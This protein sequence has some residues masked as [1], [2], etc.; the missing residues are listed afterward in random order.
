MT[1]VGDLSILDIDS[2]TLQSLTVTLTNRPDSA[3]E[4]LQANT[5]GLTGSYD[6]ATGIFAVSGTAPVATYEQILESFTY[7]NLSLTPD[8]TTRVVEVTVNDGTDSSV[9][10]T[11][12]IDIVPDQVTVSYTH[13]TLPTNREV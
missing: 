12:F 2:T 7:E 10:A 11:S 8:L 1:D 3:L 6:S 13:L 9:V 4:S 5:A